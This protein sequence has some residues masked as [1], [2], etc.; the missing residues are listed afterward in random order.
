[1]SCAFQPFHTPGPTALMS[2]AVRMVSSFNL[3]TDCITALKFSMVMR[4]DRSR[5]WATDDI[6]KCTSMS[7]ATVSLSAGEKPSH[8]QKLRAIRAPTIEWSSMR[9]LAMSCKNSAT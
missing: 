3:S 5:D 1:M 7:Q 4:S 6:I 2:A 9:P 8:G